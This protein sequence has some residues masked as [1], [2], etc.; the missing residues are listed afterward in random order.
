MSEY[1]NE[2]NGGDAPTGHAA[3]KFKLM[4]QGQEL[5]VDGRDLTILVQ[6]AFSRDDI[7]VVLE[8]RGIQFRVKGQR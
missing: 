6:G 4:I 5:T 2:A 7:S 3:G 1:G 8:S